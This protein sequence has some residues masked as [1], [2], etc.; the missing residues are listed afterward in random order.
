[1]LPPFVIPLLSSLL[2]FRPSLAGITYH[3]KQGLQQSVISVPVGLGAVEAISVV[4]VDMVLR[5]SVFV[6]HI[7][8]LVQHLRGESCCR[9]RE[10]PARL[11]FPH[12]GGE[13]TGHRLGLPQGRSLP[14]KGC[15]K[16][17]QQGHRG[18][19]GRF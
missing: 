9:N 1:M 10:A 12:G 7:Q 8:S 6:D 2:L 19:G 14:V 5:A 13:H 11:L 15:L 16:E 3:F 4:T 17:T 18:D